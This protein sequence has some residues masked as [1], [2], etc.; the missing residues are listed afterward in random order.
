MSLSFGHSF[1]TRSLES[2]TFGTTNGQEVTRKML[3]RGMY[4]NTIFDNA[5]HWQQNIVAI[6]LRFN[7]GR[8]LH[9]SRCDG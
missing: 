1:Q 3:L 9:S 4:C 6:P 5:H 7:T 2:Q 8:W